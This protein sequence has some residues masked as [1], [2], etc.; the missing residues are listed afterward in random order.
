MPYPSDSKV[1]FLF[2]SYGTKEMANDQLRF[3]IAVLDGRIMKSLPPG[4]IQVALLIRDRLKEWGFWWQVRILEFHLH[5]FQRDPR[6][7][8]DNGN[9]K[10]TVHGKGTVVGLRRIRR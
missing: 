10:G 9:E 8:V 1:G 2:M 7:L 5:R 6:R 4:R 3:A